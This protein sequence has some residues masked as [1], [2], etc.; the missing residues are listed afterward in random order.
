MDQFD[1]G[2]ITAQG[3]AQFYSVS[4]SGERVSTRTEGD[5]QALPDIIRYICVKSIISI[6]DINLIS[7]V[8]QCTGLQDFSI[9]SSSRGEI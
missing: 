7:V 9:L 5:R 8:N 2:M 4:K 3:C 6:Y 1:Y